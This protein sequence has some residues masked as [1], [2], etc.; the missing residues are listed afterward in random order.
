MRCLLSKGNDDV[1]SLAV[2]T[3]H[4]PRGGFIGELDDEII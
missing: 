3:Q 1:S 4:L 2:T